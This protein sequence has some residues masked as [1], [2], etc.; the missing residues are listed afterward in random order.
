MQCYQKKY[1]FQSSEL[2]TSKSTNISWKKQVAMI[3]IRQKLHNFY[4]NDIKIMWNYLSAKQWQ[5]LQKKQVESV[6]NHTS[7]HG[8]DLGWTLGTTFPCSL[9]ERIENKSVNNTAPQRQT[10]KT[11]GAKRCKSYRIFTFGCSSTKNDTPYRH[12]AESGFRKNPRGKTKNKKLA[13]ENSFL[14][15]LSTPKKWF[16]S[17]YCCWHY[18]TAVTLVDF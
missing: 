1:S 6:C 11:A 16:T 2:E 9:L 13:P 7:S 3:I 5:L 14:G 15:K 17:F 10:Q 12:F 4:N 8:W 18:L